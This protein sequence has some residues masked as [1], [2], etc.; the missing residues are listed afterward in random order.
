MIFMKTSLQTKANVRILPAQAAFPSGTEKLQLLSSYT[1][2]EKQDEA[3]KL[4]VQKDPKLAEIF[5]AYE[6]F[7]AREYKFASYYEQKPLGSFPNSE[8]LELLKS[9]ACTQEDLTKF[10][11]SLRDFSENK[12]FAECGLFLSA[13]LNASVH[14]NFILHIED[15]LGDAPPMDYLGYRSTKSLNIIGNVGNNAASGAEKGTIEIYGNAGNNAGVSMQTGASLIVHGNCGSGTGDE[16]WGGSILVLGNVESAGEKIQIG[17]I[18]IRKNVHWN[19]ANT[20]INGKILVWGDVLDGEAG[21]QMQGG[22]LRIKGNV[23]G[24][25]GAFLHFGAVIIVEGS[26][27]AGAGTEMDYSFGPSLLIIYGDAGPHAGYGQHGGTII[28]RGSS[29]IETADKKSG[30]T[31]HVGGEIESLGDKIT[32]GNI[33][34]KGK[35]IVKDGVRLE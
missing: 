21:F 11:I 18:E 19:V 27:G 6:G 4:E 25:A 12:D 2:I 8:E 35:Q 13:L 20:M 31:M 7:R 30:G 15:T 24:R 33:F 16:L 17:E 32:G 22:L 3:R 29:G 23:K 26:V 14:D 9:I 28:V 5:S 34:H 10:L 1:P